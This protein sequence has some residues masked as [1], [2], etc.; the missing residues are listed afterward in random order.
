VKRTP[1][2]RRTPIRKVSPKRKAYRSSDEGQAALKHMRRV[3]MLPCIVCG[4]PGPNDAH[5]CISGRYGTRKAS[6]FETVPMCRSCHL[7]GPNAIHRN[8]REWE[9]R[10]GPDYGFLDMVKKAL[11]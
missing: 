3:K 5:H 7:D 10:H 1:I 9:E 11:A 2:N 8:K 4:K 6:D